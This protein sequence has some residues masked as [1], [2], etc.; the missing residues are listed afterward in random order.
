MDQKNQKKAS[1][2]G[3]PKHGHHLPRVASDHRERLSPGVHSCSFFFC[4]LRLA[5]GNISVWFLLSWKVF[6]YCYYFL[7]FMCLLFN[8]DCSQAPEALW[9]IYGSNI[10]IHL[11]LGIF[12][13]VSSALDLNSKT[14][15]HV[16][17]AVGPNSSVE[18]DVK[19]NVRSLHF[20]LGEGADLLDSASR[21]L[22][23]SDAVKPLVQ[24]NGVF[25]R[26]S[27]C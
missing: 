3:K 15:W 23:E 7:C 12:V 20:L 13:V 1:L 21:T 4:F 14:A 17:N 5:G 18:L 8:Y 26:N 25:A 6:G 9:D 22:L 19:T 10:T 24:V 2:W 16:L 11:F 27:L